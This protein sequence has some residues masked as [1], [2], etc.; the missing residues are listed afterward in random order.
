MNQEMSLRTPD[1]L[2]AFREG[3]GTRLVPVH[4]LD[5]GGVVWECHT[6]VIQAG[7]PCQTEAK[8]DKARQI[9]FME[10]TCVSPVE[11]FATKVNTE[12]QAFNV[13]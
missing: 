3:L 10:I 1:P 8:N 4:P 5:R 13:L 7:R 9:T 2:S 11:A 6:N 12:P